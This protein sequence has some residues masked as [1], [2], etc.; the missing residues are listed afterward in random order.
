MLKLR[1]LMVIK[2]HQS[3]RT[4]INGQRVKTCHQGT[5]RFGLRNDWAIAF[6]TD[7]A[8]NNGKK[9]TLL[10]CMHCTVS[11]CIKQ[12]LVQVENRTPDGIIA[13]P[14]T[15]SDPRKAGILDDSLLYTPQ[16]TCHIQ[17]KS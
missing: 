5:T 15:R 8:I 11:I 16:L 1:K 17:T 14:A 2:S 9:P 3:G 13:V 6:A 7:N 12:D 10:S 4:H